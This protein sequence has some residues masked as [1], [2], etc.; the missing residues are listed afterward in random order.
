MQDPVAPPWATFRAAL[1]CSSSHHRRRVR[2]SC[3]VRRSASTPASV[4]SGLAHK[5]CRRQARLAGG[6]PDRHR[7]AA[8]RPDRGR[9]RWAAGANHGDGGGDKPDDPIKVE[10]QG[11]ATRPTTAST[12]GSRSEGM[13]VEIDESAG[14]RA[15]R[16]RL[17]RDSDRAG[18]GG[19]SVR[20]GRMVGPEGVDG[21]SRR[22]GWSGR[23]GRMVGPE[24]VDDWV[25]RGGWSGGGEGRGGFP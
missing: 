25:G 19:W 16:P 13:R 8:A 11:S 1:A 24:G 6:H 15:H 9:W 14:G 10:S 18:R 22:G 20:K 5:A 2:H 12:S 17:R 21:R 3:L 4:S 23:K 7:P